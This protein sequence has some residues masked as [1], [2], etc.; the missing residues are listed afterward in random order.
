MLY[1]IVTRIGGAALANWGKKNQA[2]SVFFTLFTALW[3]LLQH[4]KAAAIWR[5]LQKQ[6][7]QLKD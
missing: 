6:L 7:K 3:A 1:K 4:L 5:V 2:A